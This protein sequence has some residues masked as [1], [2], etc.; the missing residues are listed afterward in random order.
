M[1]IEVLMAEKERRGAGAE[2]AAP[3]AEGAA[4]AGAGAP[5]PP[6]PVEEPA[7][8]SMKK[9]F[10]GL[11]KSLNAVVDLVKGLKGEV[12]SLKKSAQTVPAKKPVVTT[13]PAATNDVQVLQKSEPQIQR[14]NKSE[15]I[16]FLYN[17]QKSGD[18]MVNSS[19]ISDVNSCQ[20]DAE[21][22]A[23]QTRLQKQ[24]IKFP[25]VQ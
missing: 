20:S 6:P 12:E 21:L 17:L 5:P 14:L 4:P 19:V 3:E 22:N 7:E 8:K 1:M 23:V 24:G 2:G 11:A 15:T 18:K 16:E 9:E 10:A 25:A 13:K